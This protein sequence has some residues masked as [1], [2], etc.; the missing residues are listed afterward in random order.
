MKAIVIILSIFSILVSQDNSIEG[1]RGL[2]PEL[3][4]SWETAA[5]F[6]TP[7]SIF[8]DRETELLYVSNINGR[9]QAKDGNGSISQLKPDGSIVLNPWI[10]GLNAPKGMGRFGKW[11]YVTDI[12]ELV[13]I[14]IAA[15]V[16]VRR[17]PAPDALF[18]NDIAVDSD[19][20]VYISDSSL[21]RL[22]RF[23]GE[24][25][26]QWI[27]DSALIPGINGLRW[28]NGR[29]LAGVRGAIVEIDPKTRQ[30]KNLLP[31]VTGIDGLI[32]L[33]DNGFLTSDWTGHVYYLDSAAP[34]AV[35]LDLTVQNRNAADMEFIPKQNLLVIP[36]FSANTITAYRVSDSER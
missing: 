35:L 31:H 17:F 26:R 27:S 29:L 14:D 12:D 24:S 10:T 22:Y 16:I 6:K 33:T 30:I 11:L 18:L 15:G 9:P 2:L 36:T 28:T 4:K 8:W 23:D 21:S 34:A 32:P 19:G 3:E 1:K 13:Q 5:V 7:E 25:V 20:I